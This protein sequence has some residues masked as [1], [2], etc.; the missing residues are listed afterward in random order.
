MRSA[1]FLDR[2]GTLIEERDF[3]RSLDDLHLFPW[4]L[5]AL[6]VLCRPGLAV[7]VVTNQSGVARGYFDEA[8]VR[9]AHDYLQGLLE[10]HGVGADGYYY[11]P[12]HPEGAVEAY[13]RRCGCRKPAPGLLL[14]AAR[15]LDLDVSRSY[16]VGDKRSDVELA[17]AAGATGV[18]VRSG[19]GAS[20]ERRLGEGPV[21]AVVVDTLLEA[22]H[23]IVAHHARAVPA[24][25]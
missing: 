25:H 19:Y 16:V 9:E 3:L 8:F 13:R 18:L 14:E 11:C 20:A 15:D 12:H 4:S 17:A 23:W 6:Q 10:A 24:T 5:E 7:V 22:A 1:V 21:P 2:D